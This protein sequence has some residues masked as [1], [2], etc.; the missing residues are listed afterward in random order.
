MGGKITICKNSVLEGNFLA[1][2][3]TVIISVPI[4]QDY[5]I[6]ESKIDS[7]FENELMA[8]LQPD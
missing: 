7:E 3:I 6:D 5:S 1:K 2:G 4:L 8:S